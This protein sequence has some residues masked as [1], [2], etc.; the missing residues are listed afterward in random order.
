[1]DDSTERSTIAVQ[2][3]CTRTNMIPQL[4]V[5]HDLN[6]QKLGPKVSMPTVNIAWNVARMQ[7][8]A[9]RCRDSSKASAAMGVDLKVTQHA[10]GY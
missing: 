2:F 10:L 9:L 3:E 5:E 1:M 4:N 6:S 8:R 7:S